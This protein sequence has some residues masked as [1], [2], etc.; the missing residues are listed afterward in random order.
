[1]KIGNGNLVA[2]CNYQLYNGEF[3]AVHLH[4]DNSEEI[5]AALD[6]EFG[7]CNYNARW[8][9]SNLERVAD[10][11]NAIIFEQKA[12]AASEAAA[13]LAAKR[14]AVAGTADIY[15][16]AGKRKAKMFGYEFE[17]DY[18]T[19]AYHAY[20]GADAP[21][22]VAEL[23]IGEFS[24]PISRHIQRNSKGGMWSWH[25]VIE[26][27]EVPCCNSSHT[28]KIVGEKIS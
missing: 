15:D 2:T 14:A 10:A 8:T 17:W 25:I 4:T 16:Y 6:A 22:A 7:T 27:W 5:I 20:L 13:A 19:D 28:F 21:K 18:I 9:N 12:Q 26:A 3:V 24:S 1:M 23:N 11:A